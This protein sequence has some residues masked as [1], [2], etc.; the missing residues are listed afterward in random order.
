MISKDKLLSFLKRTRPHVGRVVTERGTTVN[1]ADIIEGIG[2]ASDV[3]G[4]VNVAEYTPIIEEKPL[5]DLSDLRDKVEGGGTASVVNGEIEI[6]GNLGVTSLYTKKNGRYLPGLI[7][8]AGIGVRIQ[9]VNIGHYEFGYG[10]GSG[11]RFGLELDNGTWYTFIESN[12]VRWYRKPRSEW[13]DPL[14][15]TGASGLNVDEDQFVLRMPFGWYGYLSVVFTIAVSTPEGDRLVVVDVSGNRDGA[16]TVEQPDLPI[17]AEADGGVM[18]V[19]GRQF[20]VFGRYDPSFRVTSSEPVSKAGVGS[21]VPVISFRVK[22]DNN[23]AGVPITLAGQTLIVT[24]NAYYSLIV[25]GTLTGDSFTSFNGINP[26]ETA[27]EVDTSATAITGGQRVFGD[28]ITGGA[29]GNSTGISQDSL[30]DIELPRGSVITLVVEAI[31]TA[32]D[33]V[34]VLKAKEEW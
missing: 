14:D 13:D 4:Q 27:L 16:V 1:I 33:V 21:P 10:N 18:Y 6:D 20:G 5:P 23:W 32:T 17:F 8:M 22:S 15:G 9:D 25:D 31:S 7:G 2:K 29:I 19:G 34:A 28:L 26:T 24:E 3:F 12:G 11:N 30:P